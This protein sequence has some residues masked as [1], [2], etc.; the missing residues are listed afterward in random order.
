MLRDK[1]GD[2]VASQIMFA[3]LGI[4]GFIFAMLLKR[5]DRRE[6]HVL[7]AGPKAVVR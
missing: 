2:Y 5:A 4:V 6:G 3:S 1:T 7:D